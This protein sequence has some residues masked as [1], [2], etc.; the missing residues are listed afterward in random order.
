[1][2]ASKTNNTDEGFAV[3]E[4]QHD[5][6]ESLEGSAEELSQRERLK[7]DFL[8]ACSADNLKRV[9]VCFSCIKTE[10]DFDPLLPFLVPPLSDDDCR[11]VFTVV[12]A[13]AKLYYRLKKN[14]A[15]HDTF[16][17]G[18]EWLNKIVLKTDDDYVNYGL[19]FFAVGRCAPPETSYEERME[20]FR[21]AVQ[22][23]DRVLEKHDEDWRGLLHVHYEMFLQSEAANNGENGLR[24]RDQIIL[25]CE[26]IQEKVSDDLTCAVDVCVR[27]DVLPKAKEFRQLLFS[28]YLSEIDTIKE[29]VEHKLKKKKPDVLRKECEEAGA[30]FVALAVLVCEIERDTIKKSE[31]KQLDRKKKEIKSSQRSFIGILNLCYKKCGEVFWGVGKTDILLDTL[32]LWYERMD[33]NGHEEGELARLRRLKNP[34]NGFHDR[35]ITP[36]MQK[37]QKKKPDPEEKK[38]KA[39]ERVAR[40][41]AEQEI[42]R[43]AQAE[44]AAQKEQQK[45][46]ADAKGAF[47]GVYRKFRKLSLGEVVVFYR[48]RR[49]LSSKVMNLLRKPY[50]ENSVR[51]RARQ[52]WILAC[53][54]L[55]DA[56][57]VVMSCYLNSQLNQY[58][59]A[60][61]EEL[62]ALRTV[63]VRAW[64][65]Y[66]RLEEWKQLEQRTEVCRCRFEAVQV[67]PLK[68]SIE[69]IT[70]AAKQY[71]IHAR[72]PLFPIVAVA[73]MPKRPPCCFFPAVYKPKIRFIR[74]YLSGEADFLIE[75]CEKLFSELVWF[76]AVPSPLMCS[77]L[78]EELGAVYGELCERYPSLEQILSDEHHRL[79]PFLRLLS[80]CRTDPFKLEAWEALKKHVDELLSSSNP[81]GYIDE[82]GKLL[83]DEIEAIEA[84]SDIK[85]ISLAL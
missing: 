67:L 72:V 18:I 2:A 62:L 9:I 69:R 85:K 17:V 7:Q 38:Q 83:R 70:S 37:P 53:E 23:F 28:V 34:K 45:R 77:M 50:E 76:H 49:Q 40:I 32:I 52:E 41:R 4:E 61:Y 81:K 3:S 5:S 65:L 19:C 33:R 74:K 22:H 78:E 35:P 68:V 16:R 56:C 44:E 30:K 64:N 73:E 39:Q 36:A 27:C 25:C 10:L 51:D 15:A 11:Y 55:M 20:T 31:Q 42:Q 80:L 66:Q 46:Y 8:N 14:S 60:T 24:A 47:I 71:E 43:R 21:C 58:D 13:L 79:C 82:M 75:R 84:Q 54:G 48:R 59:A 26:N 57:D 12:H 1:M 63:F 29:S 6:T